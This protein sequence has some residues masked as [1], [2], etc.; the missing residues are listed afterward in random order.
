MAEMADYPCKNCGW[1]AMLG[2][3]YCETCSAAPYEDPR[4]PWYVEYEEWRQR[5]DKGK[6]DE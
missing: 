4:R 6:V 5:N 1:P 3:P 2:K